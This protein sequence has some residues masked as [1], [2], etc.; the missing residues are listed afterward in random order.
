MEVEILDFFAVYRGPDQ[1]VLV[2]A[3]QGPPPVQEPEHDLQELPTDLSIRLLVLPPQVPLPGTEV[4][5]LD[6]SWLCLF[7]FITC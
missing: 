7:K 2:L 4:V 3:A 6:L 5:I 1:L